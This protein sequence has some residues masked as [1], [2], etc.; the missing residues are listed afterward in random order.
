MCEQSGFFGMLLD[1]LED[2]IAVIDQAGTIIYVNRAWVEF[3]IEN[4]EPPELEWLG[5]NYLGVCNASANRGEPYAKASLTG[6]LKVLNGEEN[7]FYYEYP[8]HSPTQKRW[9]LM[10]I[11][12]LHGVAGTNFVISHVNITQRKLI[13][14][15]MEAQSLSDSL[16]GLANRRHFDHFLLGE[17]LRN[18]RER[19]PISMVMFDLDY[20]KRYN[21]SFGHMAGDEYLRR[22]GAIIAGH[23]R[24][25]TDMAARYGG[26]EFALILGNTDL[27]GAQNTAESAREA[28]AALKPGLQCS[29]CII[30]VSA[31]VACTI[32][33]QGQAEGFLVEEADKALYGAKAA[34]RNRVV[35]QTC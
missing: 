14:E 35:L 31:G 18:M 7:S 16:T 9:F 26:E 17:W 22:V 25:P 12:P 23:A 24:R 32:P 15:Q 1:C 33:A 30:S 34:G 27:L 13:E 28:V 5:I 3:G 8:C 29:D 21:D 10:R 2:H 4:G 20:F 19:T 6:I 11:V